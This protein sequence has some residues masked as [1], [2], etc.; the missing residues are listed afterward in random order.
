SWQVD[1]SRLEKRFTSAVITRLHR[2]PVVELVLTNAGSINATDVRVEFIVD[3]AWRLRSECQ[4]LEIKVPYPPQRIKP[5]EYGRFDAAYVGPL[6]LP[7]IDFTPRRD[8]D[9]TWELTEETPLQ[10]TT[11]LIARIPVLRHRGEVRLQFHLGVQHPATDPGKLV[12]LVSYAGRPKVNPTTFLLVREAPQWTA[13]ELVQHWL[14][15]HALVI[16]V[17]KER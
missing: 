14:D 10:G 15:T 17:E 7:E 6:R 12:V 9:P 13:D 2:G 3:G 11:R 16:E 1:L 4:A 8:D 5:S